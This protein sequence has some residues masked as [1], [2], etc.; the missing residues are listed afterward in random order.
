MVPRESY[1]TTRFEPQRLLNQTKISNNGQRISVL[2][3]SFYSVGHVIRIQSPPQPSNFQTSKLP[4][5]RADSAKTMVSFQLPSIVFVPGHTSHDVL[6]QVPFQ[7]WSVWSP[8]CD[9]DRDPVAIMI[10]GLLMRRGW[11]I[12]S[13]GDEWDDW[14]TASLE[15]PCHAKHL[16]LPPRFWDTLGWHARVSHSPLHPDT[17]PKTFLLYLVKIE[18]YHWNKKHV[19]QFNMYVCVYWL[20]YTIFE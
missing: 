6:L 1:T 17:E 7:L 10:D 18:K 4:W 14:F 20:L 9:P 19:H 13:F 5:H 2:Y 11:W 15:S 3:I 12:G 8:K 16:L